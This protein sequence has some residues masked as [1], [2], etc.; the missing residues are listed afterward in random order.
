MYGTPKVTLV[1]YLLLLNEIVCLNKEVR[2]KCN[3]GFDFKL[4]K[5]FISKKFN[6][7]K[8]KLCIV[9]ENKQIDKNIYV[10]T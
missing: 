3:K 1:R 2:S 7:D 9:L 8:T 4:I 5:H 10:K 6:F